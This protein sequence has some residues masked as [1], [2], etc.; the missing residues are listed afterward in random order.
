LGA[1]ERLRADVIAALPGTQG[2]VSLTDNG[3][4]G[5]DLAIGASVWSTVNYGRG[6]SLYT[7]VP[8]MDDIRITAKNDAGI[9]QSGFS[10]T[11]Y[12]GDGLVHG[13]YFGA[14]VPLNGQLVVWAIGVPAVGFD[15]SV[16]GGSPGGTTYQTLLGLVL[17]GTG[18]PWATGALTITNITSNVI[19][20]N[21]VTGIG[22]TVQPPMGVPQK[23]LSTG[24]GFVSTN[25]GLPLEAHTVTISGSNN[26]ASASQSGMVTLVAPLRVDTGPAVSGGIPLTGKMTLSFV[27]EPG[28][29]LLL[30]SGA[31]GL[32]LLGR[33]RMRNG[34]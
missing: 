18:G 32:V 28:T 1:P 16:L 24:G 17:G 21:G 25:G 8:L 4:G 34:S 31:V 14:V 12:A 7:G 3:M 29:M 11:N 13:P 22:V 15:L 20:V 6:T 30:V 2:Q 26:L 23:T 19:S 10:Y 5:H 9:F 33:R 27:P